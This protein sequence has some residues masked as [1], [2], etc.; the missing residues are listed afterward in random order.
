MTGAYEP[1]WDRDLERGRQGEM[2]ARRIAEMSRNGSAT[3]EVKTDA[4]WLKTGRFYVELECLRRG[5]WRPSGLQTTEALFWTFVAGKHE[6]E[7][8]L[9]TEHLRRAVAHAVKRHPGNGDARCANGSHPTRG[10][11]VYLV[12]IAQTRD[13]GLDEH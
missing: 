11:Y 12:D 9:A 7:M 5:V 8:T 3:V 10:A 1:R 6:V 4:W 2:F 13:E